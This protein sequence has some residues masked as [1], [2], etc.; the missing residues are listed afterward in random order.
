MKLEKSFVFKGFW[1]DLEAQYGK[2]TAQIPS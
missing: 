1:K 2:K